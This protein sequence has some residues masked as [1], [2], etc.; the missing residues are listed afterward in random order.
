MGPGCCDRSEFPVAGGIQAESVTQR[1]GLVET[2]ARMRGLKFMTSKFPLTLK[3]WDLLLPH[4]PGWQPA[5]GSGARP[6]MLHQAETL[7]FPG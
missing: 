7:C 3:S 4:C 2:E 1:Q 6:H 5:R